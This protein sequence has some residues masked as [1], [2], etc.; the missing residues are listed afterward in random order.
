MRAF[1]AKHSAVK[2]ISSI[3]NDKSVSELD[4]AQVEPH[5][6]KP[7]TG[8]EQQVRFTRSNKDKFVN[9]TITTSSCILNKAQTTEVAT[10][11]STL[12]SSQETQSA[13]AQTTEVATVPST[14]GSTQETQSA[15]MAVDQPSADGNIMSNSGDVS[16]ILRKV[17]AHLT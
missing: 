9:S 10:V 8:N 15:D 12:G 13:E 6:G 3:Q 4:S 7:L 17:F 2:S 14:L 16:G 11:P 5:D 1:C